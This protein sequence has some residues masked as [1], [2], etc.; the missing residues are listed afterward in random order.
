VPLLVVGPGICRGRRI[1]EL[2]SHVDIGPTIVDLT[3]VGHFDDATGRSVSSSLT[4]ERSSARSPIVFSVRE[5]GKAKLIGARQD[6]WKIIYDET[7]DRSAL[8]DL[9]SDPGELQNVA[10]A[11][12][13][14][15]RKFKDAIHERRSGVEQAPAYDDEELQRKRIQE[16]RSLGYVN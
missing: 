3:G 11:N 10:G 12:P 9:S 14:I 1:D 4:R 5:F 7:N 8:F 6:S 2:V 15:L 16:L 13:E